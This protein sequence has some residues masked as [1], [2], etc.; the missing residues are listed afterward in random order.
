MI[1]TAEEVG[2]LRDAEREAERRATHVREL[3]I[4][5]ARATL[6]GVASLLLSIRQA[7]WN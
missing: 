2:R 5:R 3:P 4:L 1:T 7:I 6:V